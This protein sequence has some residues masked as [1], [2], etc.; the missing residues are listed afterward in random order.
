MPAIPLSRASRAE[1]LREDP[2]LVL[3]GDADALVADLDAHRLVGDLADDLDERR[4]SGEYLTAFASRLAKTWASRSRSPRTG[5]RRARRSRPRS[6]ARVRLVGHQLAPPRR[7][8]GCRS[9]GSSSSSI[10][11]ASMLSPSR[12]WSISDDEPRRPGRG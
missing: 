9:T 5:E 4:R 12:N 11:P 10:R 2:R 8:A 3:V 6:G 1:E 7:S